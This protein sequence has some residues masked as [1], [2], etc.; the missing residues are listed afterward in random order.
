M[1]L[2]EMIFVGLSAIHGSEQFFLRPVAQL[3][4]GSGP[5]DGKF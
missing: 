1:P 2:F 3:A 4:M 5:E